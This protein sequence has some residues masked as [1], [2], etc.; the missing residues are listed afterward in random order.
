MAFTEEEMECIRVCLK[1]API[2]YDIRFKKISKEILEKIG[3]P[4]PL[5]GE[6]LPV[7]ECDLTKYEH[8]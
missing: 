8:E 6:S 5:K 2:P 7:I 3:E 1:N 4:T